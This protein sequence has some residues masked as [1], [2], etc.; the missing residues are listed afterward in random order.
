MISILIQLD[1]TKIIILVPVVLFSVPSKMIFPWTFEFT[2]WR[3]TFV[4]LP[5][6][7]VYI[8]MAIKSTFE[9][10]SFRA[11]TTLVRASMS[12]MVSTRVK[13]LVNPLTGK[14]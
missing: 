1:V 3:K 12:I 14:G 4:D 5:D 2:I 11:F 6:V 10:E 8:F 7:C 9:G 13:N